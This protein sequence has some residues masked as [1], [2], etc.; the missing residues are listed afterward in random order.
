MTIRA[1]IQSLEPS[2]LVELFQIDLSV[3]GGPVINGHGGVNGL[4]TDVIW[5]G[6]VYTPYPVEA[7]GFK[8]SGVGSL[9]RPTIQV[10]NIGGSMGALCKQYSDFA[11]CKYTRIRTFARFLDAANFPNGNPTAD[12]TQQLPLQV[13]FFDRKAE[14]N[15]QWI[16]FELA[17][18]LDMISAK[19]PNRQFIQNTCPWI[20]RGA[21]CGYTGTNYWDASDNPQTLASADVCGKR[22]SSCK[23]R[24]PQTG[25]TAAAMPFGGFPGVQTG[26]GS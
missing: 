12:P 17:S 8:M 25:A 16:K 5:N 1:E 4:M 23:L 20:Y 19:V 11:G 3:Q 6:V 15:A 21:D 7:Q 9:P 10:S 18:S 26:Q 22:L 2:S 13:W 14:E 24:F